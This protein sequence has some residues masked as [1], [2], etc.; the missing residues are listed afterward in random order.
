MNAAPE[1]QLQ[2]D[3]SDVQNALLQL[4][5]HSFRTGGSK[6]QPMPPQSPPGMNSSLWSAKEGAKDSSHSSQ[7]SSQPVTSGGL[8]FQQVMRLALCTWV[9]GS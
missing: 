4:R 9:A 8:L 2:I 1:T 3:G 7:G 5:I 6:L